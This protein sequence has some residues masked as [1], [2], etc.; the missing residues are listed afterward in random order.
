MPNKYYEYI[1]DKIFYKNVKELYMNFKMKTKE[2]KGNPDIK[3]LDPF[4]SAI[5]ISNSGVNVSDF[6]NKDEYNRR[7]GKSLSNY[8]GIFHERNIQSL[9]G[10]KDIDDIKTGEGITKPDAMSIDGNVIVEIKNKYNTVK[11][12][13]KK[14]IFE[15]LKWFLDN[16]NF[17]K[18]IFLIINNIK[19]EKKLFTFK[20]QKKEFTDERIYYYSIDEFLKEYTNDNESFAKYQIGFLKCL[21]TVLIDEENREMKEE[22]INDISENLFK[23]VYN[24]YGKD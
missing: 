9:N 23:E 4:H 7:I 22:A 2:I 15:S 11:G 19:S 1:D 8:I 14:V 20:N 16:K 5:L 24:N 17:K 13:D 6:I 18:G 21:N 12:S 3:D 10:F